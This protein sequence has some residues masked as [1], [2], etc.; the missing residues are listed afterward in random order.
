MVTKRR[1]DGERYRG[2]PIGATVA[3]LP[4]SD[5]YVSASWGG[6]NSNGH[7]GYG[8]VKRGAKKFVR[9]RTRFNE[10]QATKKLAEGMK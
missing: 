7:R 9:T 4:L 10:N 2:S 6:D 8:K 1:R 3:K 5:K